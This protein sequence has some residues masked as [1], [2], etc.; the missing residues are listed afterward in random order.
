MWAC[1]SLMSP[2]LCCPAARW[3]RR[4][5]SAAPRVG[6]MV[7]QGGGVLLRVGGCVG[8]WGLGRKRAR[9]GG[10]A[11]PRV[12]H[13]EYPST[14]PMCCGLS[15]HAPPS[16][17]PTACLLTLCTA[18]PCL[19][20]LQCT[21]W[22]ASSPCCPA[23]SARS[24]AGECFYDAGPPSRSA[25][26]ALLLLLGSIHLPE[27]RRLPSLAACPLC[28]THPTFA[29]LPLLQPLCPALQPESWGR[30]PGLQCGVGHGPG[31]QH[32]VSGQHP[33]LQHASTTAAVT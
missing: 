11:A 22:I 28:C 23:C 30:P 31:G 5:S 10:P 25:S 16:P 17:P 14:S 15:L 24:S 33:L 12:G 3:T 4:H 6:E 8:G 13:F 2:T 9:R 19:P 20:V 21:S 1:T 32:P 27:S 7:R 29:A 26:A 18:A